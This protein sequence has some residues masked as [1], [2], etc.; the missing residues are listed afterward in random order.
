MLDDRGNTAA[1]L[2]YAYVRIRSIARNANISQESLKEAAK[3]EKLCLDHE[4]ELK[5]AKCLLRF[6]EVIIRCLDDLML[7]TLCEYLYETANTFTEFYDHCYCIE[8]DKQTGKI[9]K[10]H[11]SRLLLC[12]AT[13]NI[14]AAGFHILGIDPL[15]KM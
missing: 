5:L 15:E 4:K 12:E 7:H 6:P 10:I 14:I 13:A 8:K 11:T 9:V 2:L 1:Y 3:R